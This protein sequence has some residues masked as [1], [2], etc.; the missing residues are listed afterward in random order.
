MRTF[1]FVC[2]LVCTLADGSTD[3]LRVKRILIE[4]DSAEQARE[5]LNSVATEMVHDAGSRWLDAPLECL[6]VRNARL[7]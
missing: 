5:Y 4:A 7:V 1:E 3:T 2:D 6:E